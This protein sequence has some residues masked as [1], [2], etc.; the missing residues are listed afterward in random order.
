[1]LT[2]QLLLEACKDLKPKL[3]DTVPVMVETLLNQFEAG[4]ATE[5]ER[6]AVASVEAIMAGGCKL[7]EA[8]LAPLAKKH[9][10]Q[11]CGKDRALCDKM[12]C[13]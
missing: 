5:E 8:L 7:N 2:A 4:H 6:D 3:I 12:H 11:Y 10:L 9:G 1:M 13:C